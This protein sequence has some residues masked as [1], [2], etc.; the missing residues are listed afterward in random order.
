ML[1]GS[2]SLGNIASR[3]HPGNGE[4]GKKLESARQAVIVGRRVRA[5][6]KVSLAKMCLNL[7]PP[8]FQTTE[9]QSSA[10]Y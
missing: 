10:N 2:N 3:H 8:R 7:M 1:A 6:P 5:K 9:G 4:D